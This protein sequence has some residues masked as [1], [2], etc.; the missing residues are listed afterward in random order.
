MVVTR[1]RP[2]VRLERP[3]PRRCD[4]FLAQV[5]ASRTL[6]RGFVSPPS[7]VGAYDAWTKRMRGD[8]Y[9]AHLVVE[10]VSDALAG[11]VNLNEIVR[12]GFQSAFLGYYVFAPFDGCG[13]MAVGL[14][15]VI[16]R[17][18]GKLGLHRL[19]ANIQVENEASV[20]LV[21]GLGFRHEGD[22]PRYLKLGGRWRDH[23]RYALLREEWR[24]HA[25]RGRGET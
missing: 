5:W 8:R 2:L 24:A 9:E 4:E 12:G 3:T 20:A 14:S 21:R 19:E 7:D 13:L 18:F 10:S 6:H 25:P 11:V 17:A 22:S 15:Q 23:H 1:K 16:A